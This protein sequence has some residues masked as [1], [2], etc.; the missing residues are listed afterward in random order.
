MLD[1]SHAKTPPWGHQNKKTLRPLAA[2]GL[3]RIEEFQAMSLGPRGPN[4]ADPDLDAKADAWRGDHDG[5]GHF[6][7]QR[8]IRPRE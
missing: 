7:K 3:S 2:S 8:T 1:S 4:N 6:A 5:L